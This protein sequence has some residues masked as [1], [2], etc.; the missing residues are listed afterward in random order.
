[1][2]QPYTEDDA[3]SWIKHNLNSANWMN[4]GPWTLESGSRGPPIP[5]TY[6]ITHNNA[7]I[8]QIGFEANAPN[9]VYART[10]EIGYWLSE[11]YWG[12]GVMGQ[13]VPAFVEWV[14]EN[15]QILV[16]IEAGVYDRNKGSQ[17]VLQKAGFVV[18]GVR[19]CKYIKN[20]AVGD[21]VMM[22][23]VRPGFDKEKQ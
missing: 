10:A 12:Q 9:E 21:E 19:K 8:G 16:R 2:P 23:L 5:R 13:I 15:F 7:A 14:F 20:G 17:R 18:E 4:S 1:M 22:G 11:E 6:A 3:I